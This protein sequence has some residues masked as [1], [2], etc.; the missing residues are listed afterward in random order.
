MGRE[1]GRAGEEAR[2][3]GGR[4]VKLLT[5]EQKGSGEGRREVERKETERK[6]REE[7]KEREGRR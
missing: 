3:E 4:K 1:S 7:S 2:T 6:K 5:R